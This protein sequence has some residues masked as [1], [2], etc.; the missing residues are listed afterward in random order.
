MFVV[1]VPMAFKKG[2]LLVENKV[3]RVVCELEFAFVVG[4][5]LFDVEVP[6]GCGKTALTVGDG[7]GKGVGENDGTDA[8][9][10]GD[11]V[12]EEPKGVVG[13]GGGEG[14]VGV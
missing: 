12:V 8:V 6:P 7:V 14:A 3:V 2:V 5:F 10:V 11:F 9:L 1:F 4:Y 13:N